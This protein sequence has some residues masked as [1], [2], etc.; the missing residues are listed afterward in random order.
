LSG[1]SRQTALPAGRDSKRF[2]YIFEELCSEKMG[3]Q[4]SSCKERIPSS[5]PVILESDSKNTL[6][7]S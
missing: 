3:N 4:N 5:P 7:L 1:E 6:V 2:S